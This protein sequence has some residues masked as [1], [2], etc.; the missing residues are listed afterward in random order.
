MFLEIGLLSVVSS[1]LQDQTCCI[2]NVVFLQLTHLTFRSYE[3]EDITHAF[4]IALPGALG[5]LYFVTPFTLWTTSIAVGTYLAV[6]CVS[7]IAYRLSPF[8]PL[9]RYP[10]PL[11]NK[12]TQLAPMWTVFTGRQH[13]VNHALHA[14]Y[15]PIVR[16]GKI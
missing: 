5:S 3:P 14:K 15:G 13:L 7:V 1:L 2:F 10:G 9:A 16:V 4:L 12:V 8:H 6:L 11:L